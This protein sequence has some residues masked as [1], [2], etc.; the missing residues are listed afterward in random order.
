MEGM[1]EH[2]WQRP[3]RIGHRGAAGH[4]PENTLLSI[5]TALAMGADVIEIDVHRS[6]DGQLIV[7]HDE[8]V[9]RTTNGSGCI[10]DL[11]LPQLQALEM[12]AQQRVPTLPEVLQ[13]VKGRAGLMVEIKVRHIVPMIMIATADYPDVSVFYASF[14]HS[15]LLRVR[16]L[17]PAAQTIALIEAV[18]V[19][20]TAFATDA[21][22]THAGVAFQSLERD[23]VRGLKDAGLAVFTYTVDEARDIAHARSLGVDGLI[24]NFPDRLMQP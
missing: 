12:A 4:A 20:L 3:L 22:A 6:L 1:M 8:R 19:S 13:A 7:M 9:D 21:R 14:F 5:E 16:E 17:A 23:Y 11:T 10:R 24:S 18:P 2:T 15:E